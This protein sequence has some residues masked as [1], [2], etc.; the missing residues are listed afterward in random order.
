MVIIPEQFTVKAQELLIPTWLYKMVAS[1]EAAIFNCQCDQMQSC[2]ARLWNHLFNET[3]ALIGSMPRLIILLR[4][5]NSI[6]TCI[7]GDLRVF[8][9]V[10]VV[11]IPAAM[12]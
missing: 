5:P 11:K 12:F 10:G 1:M 6:E 8:F 9:V 4:I 2:E 3:E 7:F